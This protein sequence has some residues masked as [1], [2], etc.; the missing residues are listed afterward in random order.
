MALNNTKPVLMLLIPLLMLHRN[1]DTSFEFPNFSG[2]Y[3]SELITLQGD[4]FESK[5]VITLTKVQNGAMMPNSAGRATYALPVRLWNSQTGKVARFNTTFSFEITYGF[6]LAET[7]DGISFFLAPFHSQ[8]PPHAD[9][10]YLGLLSPDTA[11]RNTDKNQLVAVEFDMHP[12]SWDPAVPHIGIDVNSI[13]SVKTVPWKN[14]VG[15]LIVFATVTYDPVSQNLSV[16]VRDGP[17][18]SLVIDLKSVLPEWVSVGFSG[19]TGKFTEVHDIH[20]WSFSSSFD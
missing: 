7:G 9:G 5:G 2:P 4:A 1:S 12:N 20:S 16:A 14:V 3:A 15:L 11:L 18:A 8:M 10:G 13:A 6:D 19:S 17:T